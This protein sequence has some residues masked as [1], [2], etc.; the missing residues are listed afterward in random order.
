MIRTMTT[1]NKDL[2]G[3]TVGILSDVEY[4]AIQLTFTLAGFEAYPLPSGTIYRGPV[5]QGKP[6]AIAVILDEPEPPTIRC[7]DCRK[8]ARP[9]DPLHEVDFEGYVLYFCGDCINRNRHGIR[10]TITP[11]AVVA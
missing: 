8:T 6:C 11:N 4:E 5:I 10:R 7:G 3:V 2:P 9:Q 1:I